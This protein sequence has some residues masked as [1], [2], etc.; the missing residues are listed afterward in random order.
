MAQKV[1]QTVPKKGHLLRNLFLG[2]LLVIVIAAAAFYYLYLSGGIANLALQAMS[3]PSN[4]TAL[5]QQKIGAITE[6]KLGYLGSLKAN[7]TLPLVGDPEITVPFNVSL[8]KYYNDTRVTVSLSGAQDLGI[9]NFSA[10]GILMNGGST[11]YV[12]YNVE[13]AGYT[14]ANAS[15]TSPLS[16]LKTLTKIL[17]ISQ[18]SNFAVSKVSPSFY[19]GAS[20]WFVSGNGTVAVSAP[21]MSAQKAH[22]SFSA[23]LSPTYYIPLYLNADI[24]PQSG[25][26]INVTLRNV[27]M[28]QATSQAE[29]NTLPGPLGG[30]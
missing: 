3:N 24:A 30:T 18:I 23:C 21:W 29:V 11:A 19:N 28:T 17:N 25:S 2:V 15:N 10:V 8:L 1:E 20:C 5:I 14:C 7:V 9:R 27:N 13:N 6:L 22:V 26:A 12:C 16:M 4:L